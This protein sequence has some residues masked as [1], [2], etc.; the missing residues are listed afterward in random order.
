MKACVVYESLFGNTEQLAHA[1]ARG[2]GDVPVLEVSTATAADL[3][4]V[5]LVVL[6]GPT[7]AF[8]MT[9]PSTRQD[10]HRQG[11]PSGDDRRGLREL[12]AELPR[13]IST[14]VATFDTR[15]AKAK[16]LPG[17][18]AKA[19]TKQL[20]RHHHAEVR[21]QESFYVEDT[22]GPLLDGELDR[23]TAWGQRLVADLGED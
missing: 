2:M 6:G 23:A 12:I 17:S 16:H 13:S 22:P 18:A 11:A 7:H 20:R 10:A 1:V 19:A 9:R 4:Q 8:S 5:D 14:P 15:V 3:D 21:A